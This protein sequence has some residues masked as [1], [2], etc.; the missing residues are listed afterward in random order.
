MLLYAEAQRQQVRS[1][2][3]Q[4]LELPGKFLHQMEQ[5]HCQHGK[6]VVVEEVGQ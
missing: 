1:K 4:E 5:E 6:Q 3:Y 2:A